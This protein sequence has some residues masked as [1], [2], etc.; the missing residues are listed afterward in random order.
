M[1]ISCFVFCLVYVTPYTG[2]IRIL[3]N[4]GPGVY[5]TSYKGDTLYR[6]TPI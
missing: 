1:Y 6:S 5:G 2:N 4:T 3:H